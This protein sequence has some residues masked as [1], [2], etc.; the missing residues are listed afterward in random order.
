MAFIAFD[1]V[2][3]L[4]PGSVH[5]AVDRVSF[6]IRQG[7]FLTLLGP[8]GS[9]KTTSLM[10]LA[11]F[12]GVTSGAIRLEGQPIERLPAHQRNMGVVFQSYSLFPHLSVA[13][14]VA[15]PLKVRKLAAA[16]I[17]AR[18]ERAL[19]RVHL[20]DFAGRRPNQLSGGQQQR[21]ALARALV[22]EPR[23]VLMDEPLA[24]LDKRLREEMQLEIRRLH[25]E[26]GVT[27]VYVTHD[28]SEAMT[29]SDRVAVFNQGRIEQLDVPSALYDAPANPFVAGFLGDNNRAIGTVAGHAGATVRVAL[30]GGSSVVAARASAALAAALGAASAAARDVTLCIRPER[31]C[32]LG[33]A[34]DAS[35]I[36]ATVVD[37]IHQ[38]DHWRMIARLDHGAADAAAWHVK[39][40]PGGVPAGA[41]PGAQVRLAFAAD[42]AWVF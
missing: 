21:V 13:D 20:R 5:P 37:L 39:L 17:A 36:G 28:Q 10:M 41:R 38:G 33:A 14:N 29:L 4:Y 3:K 30:A 32:V 11:G 40:P 27:M 34:E 24:A 18:V 42:D 15:F 26:V 22:F 35:G 6:E 25:R 16:E 19:D 23:L 9:G 31:L 12:E 1:N 7:E 8:S 2:T